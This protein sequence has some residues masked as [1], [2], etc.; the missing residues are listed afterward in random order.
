MELIDT[1]EWMNSPDYKM[2]FVAEFHQTRLRYQKLKD[3]LEM[4]KNGVLGFTPTCPIDLLEKQL[5]AMSDYLYV[6]IHRAHIEDINLFV[7]VSLP[8]EQE[9]I[10]Q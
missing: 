3:M 5:Q 4:H 7:K 6:L 1:V 10:K 9:V 8:S 2:R